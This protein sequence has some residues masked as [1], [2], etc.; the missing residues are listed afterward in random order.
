MKKNFQIIDNA[1]LDALDEKARKSERLRENLCFHKSTEDKVQRMIN[2]FMPGTVVLKQKHIKD[3]IFV[4]LR[5]VME[6]TFYNDDL[7]LEYS[8][9]L[10]PEAGMYGVNIPAGVIHCLKAIEPTVIFEIKEGPFRIE[11]TVFYK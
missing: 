9:I 2:S 8:V 7:T 4:L 5:G 1:L 10:N 6:V 3:E 11:D